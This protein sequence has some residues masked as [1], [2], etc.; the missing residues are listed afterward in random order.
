VKAVVITR[1]PWAVENGVLTPT[2]KIR[3]EALNRKYAEQ[4]EYWFEKGER[5]IWE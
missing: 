3:R 2:L 5:V 1:E 4:Y